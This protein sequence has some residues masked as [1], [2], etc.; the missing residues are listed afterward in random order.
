MKVAVVLI[1]LGLVGMAFGLKVDEEKAKTDEE[2][3]LNSALLPISQVISPAKMDS[4][5]M[6]APDMLHRSRRGFRSYFYN[7]LD[8]IA[9]SV[10]ASI[11]SEG[12]GLLYAV[13][14]TCGEKS[15]CK[16]ICT[17]QK[18][19]HQGPKEVQSLQWACSESLHVYKRQPSLADNYE[20]YTDSH[21]LGLA[22]YRHYSCTIGGCGPNYCCCRAA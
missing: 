11:P 9:M 2:L 8:E 1:A 18:L 5:D 12:P 14:R 3:G 22:I 13:R 19:R 16:D 15:T 21:K 7:Y 4:G 6:S 20:D 17:D 10:C